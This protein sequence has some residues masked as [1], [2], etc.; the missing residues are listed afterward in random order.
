MY[1]FIH[2]NSL[3]CHGEETEVVFNARS[4]LFILLKTSS[5]EEFNPIL[6]NTVEALFHYKTQPNPNSYFWNTVWESADLCWPLVPA[7]ASYDTKRDGTTWRI[8]HHVLRILREGGQGL[9]SQSYQSF[10]Y[11]LNSQNTRFAAF[12]VIQNLGILIVT[13]R[14]SPSADL[15]QIT[16]TLK[17]TV[18][19]RL[20]KRQSCTVN[21]GP[22]QVHPY[23]DDHIP[24]T[25]TIYNF[26]YNC[27]Y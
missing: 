4:N 10:W 8:I 14:N 24:P 15:I 9:V 21:N 1:W 26:T 16:S 7:Q 13:N 25:F 27:H 3:E 20:S 19:H 6:V 18:L 11:L 5:G 12:W 17:M 2:D 23:W 22:I